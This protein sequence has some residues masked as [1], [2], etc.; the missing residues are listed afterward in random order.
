LGGNHTPT[1]IAQSLIDTQ[2]IMLE[3]AKKKKITQET[4]ETQETL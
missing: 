4:Q 3:N 1:F 2:Q